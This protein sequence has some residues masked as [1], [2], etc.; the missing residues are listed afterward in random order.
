M[1]SSDSPS[2]SPADSLTRDDLIAHIA[3][4]EKPPQ[5]WKLGVEHEKFGFHQNALTPLQYDGASGV[6][7]FL[8]AM[9]RFGWQPVR[10]NGQIIAL[11]SGS[12]PRT[13]GAVSLEPGGQF[14][15]S[16]QPLACVHENCSEVHT[17][18]AQVREIGGELGI[19][20]LGAGFAPHWRREQMPVMPKER[21]QIMAR[22][23]PSRGA[24]GLDMMFRTCTI[25]VNLDF[26]SEAD[27]VRKTQLAMNLQPLACALF[28]NSPFRDGKPAGLLSARAFAWHDT[29]PDRTGMPACFFEPGFGYERYADYA[30]D[31]P[32]YFVRRDGR[33]ID[34]A[35]QSFRDFMA[36]RLAAL[37]GV[38]PRLSDW[39]DHL[40]TLFPEVR[41]KTFI[42]MRGA[43]G[44]GWDR[45]CALPAFW[46][47][48]LYDDDSRAA[49][50][51]EVK[52]WTQADRLA[53]RRD[54]CTLGLAAEVRGVTMRD[55]AK[56]MLNLARQGLE[57]RRRLD[58]K[59]QS[60]A[61]FLDALDDIVQSGRTPAEDLLARYHQNWQGDVR[62][63][64]A[65]YAY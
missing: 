39:K 18:L 17:H 38:L 60:E 37:P 55:L 44:G 22:Y 28:A 15:L 35:G 4:G 45:I 19:G 11:E 6:G 32:M 26:A 49:A 25:Q 50:W 33:Y 62:R 41:V 65:E 10:E 48:L 42:E 56:R 1:P 36:G 54:V 9:C 14:E 27:M 29:D 34:A 7:A 12:D 3:S 51:E 5:D 8:A 24:L 58:G 46:A 20:F 61:V 64:F 43:D 59:G 47:G 52:T 63:I 53:L 23:M 57:R 40:T 13:S 21:Y 30:L 16:G 2:D 31:V